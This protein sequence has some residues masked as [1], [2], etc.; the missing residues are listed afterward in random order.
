MVGTNYQ[1]YIF[2]E[3][4][5][6]AAFDYFVK[7]P[8]IGADFLSRRTNVEKAAWLYRFTRKNNID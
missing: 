8:D 5:V 4:E 7:N 6:S 3:N 2:N 1:Y